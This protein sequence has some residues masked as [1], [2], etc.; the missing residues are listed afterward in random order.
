MAEYSIMKH[1]SLLASFTVTFLFCCYCYCLTALLKYNIDNKK[2][3]VFNAHNRWVCICGNL[4]M[5]RLR[6]PSP[7][8]KTLCSQGDYDFLWKI[9]H[10]H[11]STNNTLELEEFQKDPAVSACTSAVLAPVGDRLRPPGWSDSS[12]LPPWAACMDKGRRAPIFSAGVR[13]PQSLSN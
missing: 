12:F 5:H 10:A 7:V 1:C 9:S 6:K 8:T 2:P 11:L 4:R 3:H 13:G